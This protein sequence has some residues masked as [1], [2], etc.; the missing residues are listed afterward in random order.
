MTSEGLDS[1]AAPIFGGSVIPTGRGVSEIGRVPVVDHSSGRRRLD[2]MLEESFKNID[3][4]VYDTPHPPLG[5]RKKKHVDSGNLYYMSG[6]LSTDPSPRHVRGN[7]FLARSTGDMKT[8]TMDNKFKSTNQSAERDEEG[9]A[10]LNQF[11]SGNKDRNENQFTPSPPSCGSRG[12]STPSITS[13]S[14]SPGESSGEDGKSVQ[15]GARLSS[16]QVQRE[17]PIPAPQPWTGL[18]ILNPFSDHLLRTP[19]NRGQPHR[20]ETVSTAQTQEDGLKPS[21]PQEHECGVSVEGLSEPDSSPLSGFPRSKTDKNGK[22]ERKKKK[23]K[24]KKKHQMEQQL[25]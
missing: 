5:L 14:N 18:G 4:L 11:G 7:P 13:Q 8:Y 6:A 10:G 19:T 12:I 3:A 24:K 25:T 23:K 15:N 21:Q 22:S 17:T 20:L 9:N 2:E 16:R 1:E